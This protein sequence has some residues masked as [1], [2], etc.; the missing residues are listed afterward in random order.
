[1]MSNDDSVI[2][3]LAKIIFGFMDITN[4]LKEELK[5]DKLQIISQQCGIDL[6]NASKKS[7]RKLMTKM[8]KKNDSINI[9][10]LKIDDIS[11]KINKLLDIN[12]SITHENAANKNDIKNILAMNNNILKLMCNY[13]DDVARTYLVQIFERR[14][15]PI[16]IIDLDI[17][18]FITGIIKYIDSEIFLIKN[19]VICQEA[20]YIGV[21]STRDLIIKRLDK[22]KIELLKAKL[23]G[24]LTGIEKTLTNISVIDMHEDI[25]N[26]NTEYYF[27]DPDY[28]KIIKEFE[29]LMAENELI[30]YLK[31]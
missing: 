19:K 3:I 5:E 28:D 8:K 26:I 4:K 17:D 15:S 23:Q 14:L 12:N 16:N 13:Y 1:M 24:V 7:I 27:D 2:L 29:R 25:K 22:I 11:I 21:N 31:K 6:H 18:P 30:S 9:S 20:K 10:K